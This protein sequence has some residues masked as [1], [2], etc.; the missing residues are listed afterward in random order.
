M[1][2]SHCTEPSLDELFSDIAMQLLMRRDGVKESDLRRLLDELSAARSAV[3]VGIASKQDSPMQHKPSAQ[4]GERYVAIRPT[5]GGR[6][7]RV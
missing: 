4:I 5:A 3:S 7:E 2:R 1:C 6:R